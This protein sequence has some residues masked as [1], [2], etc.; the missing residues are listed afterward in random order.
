MN[1]KQLF[2]I[3][4]K[5]RQRVLAI[6]NSLL[7]QSGIYAFTRQ[8]ENGLKFAYI[9][10]AVN[11]LDRV[12]QHLSQYDHLGLSIKKRGLGG[13]DG[14]TCFALEY[15]DKCALD[16]RERFYIKE[17]ADKGYQLFNATTGG[18]DG[19]KEVIKQKPRKNYTDGLREGREKAIAEI[20][21]LYRQQYETKMNGELTVMAVK[22][23][24]KFKELLEESK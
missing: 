7:E 3:K 18:Q 15:A 6:D 14:W 13:V 9:G 20:A 8:D 12:A 22:A 16:E 17:Y 19:E 23:M 11:L 21:K 1:Y 4:N 5:N 2:T 10:Q 24:A